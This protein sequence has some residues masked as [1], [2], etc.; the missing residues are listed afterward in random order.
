MF[1][2]GLL[3]FFILGIII[4][5][6]FQKLDLIEQLVDLYYKMGT[7]NLRVVCFG[8]GKRSSIPKKELIRNDNIW[9]C[10]NCL[11]T[12]KLTLEEGGKGASLSVPLQ[13]NECVNPGYCLLCTSNNRS[14][15]EM[16]QSRKHISSKST[17]FWQQENVFCRECLHNQTILISALSYDAPPVRQTNF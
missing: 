13:H 1:V 6:H 17:N 10:R 16:V 11:S 3:Y 12:N 15:L 5:H 2:E 9:N 7:S 8:C 14:N 4:V